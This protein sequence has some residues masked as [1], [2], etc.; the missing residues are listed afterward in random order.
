MRIQLLSINFAPERTGIAP[1]S[2][3]LARHLSRE[4]DVTVLTGLP[5]YPDWVV[6]L[7]YRQWRTDEVTERLRIVRLAHFVPRSPGTVSR[8]TY[9]VTYAARA[10]AAGRRFPADLVLAVIPAL[11]G[12]QAA[13]LLGRIHRA[14]VGLIVQDIMGTAALQGGVRGGRQV[15]RLATGAERSA[16]RA[17]DGVA[18]IHPRLAEELQ[19]IGG[20]TTLP[21]VIY[22]W[23][24]LPRPDKLANVRHELGWK[25]DEVIALHSGNMGNKQNLENVVDAARLAERSGS[26]VRFVLAGD[27]NQRSK[28]ER[29]AARCA[30]LSFQLSVPDDQYLNMLAS[31][32]VLLV[33]ERPGM[34]EMSLPSKLTS[35]MVAGRPIVAATDPTSA[36]AEF[37]EASGGGLVVAAGQPEQ[38][39]ATID[40]LVSDPARAEAVARQAREFADNHLT[41]R[42]A[43]DDYTVWIESLA[44]SKR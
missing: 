10:A 12:A 38:L 9:E 39:L 16:L 44:A 31:A 14:P 42:G 17:A 24:H 21:S 25:D 18:T 6:P 26:K 20:L 29:Y 13:R 5:H 32:D 43:L 33:N 22:N 41:P 3:A 19:R 27:G 4:H 37:V 2:T 7:G 23:T 36:T 15:A 35:Y 30:R 28:L 1:Y 40:E 8:A 34:R 11:F